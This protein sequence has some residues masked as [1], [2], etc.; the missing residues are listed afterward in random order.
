MVPT[1]NLLKV[2]L[3]YLSD[4]KCINNNDKGTVIIY[5]YCN[6]SNYYYKF[7]DLILVHTYTNINTHMRHNFRLF[8]EGRSKNIEN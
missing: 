1:T 7:Q 6:N 3:W 5:L 8:Y 4:R 2:L